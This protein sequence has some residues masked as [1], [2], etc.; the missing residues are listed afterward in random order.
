MDRQKKVPG[1]RLGRLARLAAVGAKS[2]ASRLLNR[3][4]H[5]SA[6]QTAEVL[7]TLRG[8]AAKI[9]QMT[10]YVDGMVP[11]E[12]RDAYEKG[13]GS[14]L[15]ATPTSS[16]VEIRRAIERELGQSVE[17][18]FEKWDDTPI[19]SASIGQV[20]R[21]TLKDGREVAVKIQHPGIVDAVESDLNNMGLLEM[22]VGMLGAKKF[23]SKRL[24]EELRTRFREE[25]DYGLEAERQN[26]FRDLHAGDPTIRIP[27]VI[28]S[29][30]TKHM[31]TTEFVTGL[32]FDE[33][34]KRPESERKL[35]CETLWRFVYKGNVVGGMFNADPHPGN[36]IF[37]PEG[38]VYFLDFGCVQKLEEDRRVKGWQLHHTAI[39]RDE[40][41]FKTAVR[42]VMQTKGGT[43]EERTLRQMRAIYRPL[44][45]SPFRITR[46]YST[47]LLT[48]FKQ[49]T[50]ESRKS[51]KEE[52]YVPLPPGILFMNRLQF[53]FYSVLAR[54]NA[55]VDYAEVDRGFLHEAK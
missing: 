44:F 20:H 3:D 19:A 37:A 7:G 34:C 15:A 40:A 11:E 8:L 30:S 43:H 18:L 38:R 52:N 46:E 49:L 10:A 6:K 33:A 51:S 45:E 13:M 27:E 42:S 23:D 54:L 50:Q 41:G 25:L 9:G 16:P 35:W 17:D 48:Q 4:A 21:A 53:G 31:L 29:H 5:D 39:A 26:L 47:G 36:Y 2:G 14:L 1:G 22:A 12:H 24:F 55:E 28:D 32:T